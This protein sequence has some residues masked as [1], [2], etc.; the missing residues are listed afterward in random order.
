MATCT[1]NNLDVDG[2]FSFVFKSYV[3]PGHSK[4]AHAAPAFLL[5]TQSNVIYFFV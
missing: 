4:L 5:R 3:P 1:T 2:T